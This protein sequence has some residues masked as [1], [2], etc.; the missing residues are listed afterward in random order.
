M[1]SLLTI[2]LA[3]IAPCL[4]AASLIQ[5]ADSAYAA[6]NYRQAIELYTKAINTDGA[7]APAWYNLGN[8]YYRANHPGQAILCYER[9]L[10]INPAMSE[11]RQNLEFVNSKIVDRPGE[12][13]TFIG[14]ALDRAANLTTSNAWAWTAFTLFALTLAGVACY[15]FAYNVALRKTGFFGSIVTLVATLCALFFAFRAASLASDTSTAI[16]TAPSS[17]LSTAPRTPATRAEEAMLLHEGTKL[18]ILDSV[19]SAT[20]TVGSRMWMDVEV[21]NTHRAW[22]NAADIERV[23]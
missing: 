1:K 14:N 2:L 15:L 12:R 4:S 22:I 10:R 7:S 5:Q 17:I 20:D 16:V 23:R 11:A 19:E 13:G 9:A 6:D 18:R 8:A 21:D 3:L